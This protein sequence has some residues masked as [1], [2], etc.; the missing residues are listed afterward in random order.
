M[1]E[2]GSENLLGGRLVGFASPVVDVEGCMWAVLGAASRSLVVG[3]RVVEL[4]GRWVEVKGLVSFF[5]AALLSST[6]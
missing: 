6:I 2:A 5:L 1:V 3:S 4:V